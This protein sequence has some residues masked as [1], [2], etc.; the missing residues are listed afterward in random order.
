MDERSL[1]GAA[2]KALREALRLPGGEFAIKCGMSHGQLS[3]IEADRK[4][5]SAEAARRICAALTAAF[6]APSHP[7]VQVDVWK[8]ITN[9]SPIELEETA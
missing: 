5:A 8:A 2:V 4:P 7:R 9:P 6:P 1:N 3:N